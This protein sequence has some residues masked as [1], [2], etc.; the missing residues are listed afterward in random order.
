MRISRL[1]LAALS[2]TSL[3]LC[4]AHASAGS[5]DITLQ[6]FGQQVGQVGLGQGLSVD[7]DDVGFEHLTRD[8]SLAILPR[9]LA[10]GETL[11]QAGFAIQVDQSFSNIDQTQDY[12]IKATFDEQPASTLTTTQFHVRKGLPLGL[13]L[14]A[15]VNGLWSSKLF[16]IGGELRW[17][18]HEDFFGGMPDFTIRGFG[19]T[20]LGNADLSISGGGL[21][22]IVSYPIGVASVVNITPF[23]GYNLSV[24]SSSSR[25]LDVTP[26]DPSPPVTDSSDPSRNNKPEFVFGPVTQIMHQA[27]IGV[28][29]QFAVLDV[30]LQAAVGSPVQTYSMS[31]GFDF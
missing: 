3:S 16:F 5:N 18:L 20:M 26:A 27:L 25:L 17:S 12:W 23:A 7:Q 15:M 21:D 13:E 10:T 24:T 14:G 28:R 6:R 9:G 8:L 29:T 4:A 1:A 11:G 2:A 19:G 31:V 30:S 22:A